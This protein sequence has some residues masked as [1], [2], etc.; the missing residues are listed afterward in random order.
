MKLFGPQVE[1]AA[2]VM[3]KSLC[4]SK[5]VVKMFFSGDQYPQSNVFTSF[6]DISCAGQLSYGD[7][8]EIIAI[9]L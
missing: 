6:S 4:S 1:L 2:N 9:L 5:V 7:R 8:L 3:V